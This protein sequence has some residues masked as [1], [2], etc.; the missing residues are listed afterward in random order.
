MAGFG[1]CAAF[2]LYVYRDQDQPPLPDGWSIL[3]DCPDELQYEGY[4][5]VA[6]INVTTL[7]P[8]FS[9]CDVV[10]AHRGTVASTWDT[11][12]DFL[13]ALG[14]TPA[15]FS[16]GAYLFDEYVRQYMDKNYPETSYTYS[17]SHTGHSLG[18]ILAE[19]CVASS[20]DS[21]CSTGITFESPGSKPII[22]DME[23]QKILPPGALSWAEQMVCTALADVDVVNTCN[24]QV[25]SQ[26]YPVDIS[27][28]GYDYQS[29]STDAGT[30]PPGITIYMVNYTFRDQH[31][32]VNMYQYWQEKKEYVFVKKESAQDT[33]WP[34]GF[35]NGYQCY[36][37]YNLR[38]GYWDGYMLY[39]WISNP[40]IHAKYNNNFEQW[41]QF[42]ISNLITQKTNFMFFKP[43]SKTVIGADEQHC[44]E[45]QEDVDKKIMDGYVLL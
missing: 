11:W 31:K 3:V 43:A 17:I 39:I 9:M 32:M 2:S 15:Q 33:P 38:Q 34:V 4:F 26:I 36:M 13:I 1:E 20:C 30:M 24:E 21:T 10:I 42:F 14:K 44:M 18:A 19:L 27:P 7:T 35:E 28:I 22:A 41:A 29:D 8:D 37:N 6:F 12:N 23:S 5:A 25:S 40:D 16:K 45:N